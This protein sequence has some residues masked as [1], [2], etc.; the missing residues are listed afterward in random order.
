MANVVALQFAP[1]SLV[2]PLG[3]ISLV[4]N[5]IVAPWLNK[6][7]WGWK[8]IVGVILIVGGSSMVV[9]FSGYAAKGKIG[10]CIRILEAVR[11]LIF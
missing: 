8:D 9:A 7:R 3:S 6:E 11:R 1:Q 10:L 2:A 5:V 4:V